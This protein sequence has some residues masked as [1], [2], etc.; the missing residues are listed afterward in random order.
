MTRW[1]VVD[2][3]KTAQETGHSMAIVTP[4]SEASRRNEITGTVHFQ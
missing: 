2:F 3:R 1:K 4:G